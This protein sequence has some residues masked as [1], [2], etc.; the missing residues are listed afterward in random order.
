[1]LIL[2]SGTDTSV[3]FTLTDSY[4]PTSLYGPIGINDRYCI[5]AAWDDAQPGVQHVSPPI[6]I[7]VPYPTSVRGKRRSD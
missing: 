1:M 5:L 2:S 4:I 3:T 7:H 6:Y